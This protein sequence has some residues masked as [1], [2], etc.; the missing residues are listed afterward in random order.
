MRIAVGQ[1]VL[2]IRNFVSK[3]SATTW[4]I[5]CVCMLFTSLVVTRVETIT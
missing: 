2:N 5:F 1:N 3:Q 4:V